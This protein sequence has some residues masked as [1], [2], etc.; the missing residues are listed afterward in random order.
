M[1]ILNGVNYAQMIANPS[2]KVDPGLID[3][4]VKVIMEEYNLA[5]IVIPINDEIQGPSLPAGA[6]V[7][8]AYVMIPQ[9]LGT[10]GIF[11]L[12]HRAS[13][14][15]DGSVAAA[16]AD[17]FVASADAG[18]TAVMARAATEA[19]IM[20]RFGSAASLVLTCTEATTLTAGKIY[21]CVSYVI[22]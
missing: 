7:I 22:D 18:G 1:A 8:D 20:K 11:S 15:Q 9:S 10:A 4:K 2:E 19:G 5:G 13:T 14:L 16:D 6:K 21:F 3:G 12:G 17:A